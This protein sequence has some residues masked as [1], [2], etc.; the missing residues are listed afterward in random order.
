MDFRKDA[1]HSDIQCEFLREYYTRTYSKIFE[2]ILYSNVQYDFYT[3]LGRT[4]RF[5]ILYYTRT[6]STIFYFVLHLDVQYDFD[7]ILYSDV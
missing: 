7:F 4:V 5:L 6:Y 1:L 3:A 2:F